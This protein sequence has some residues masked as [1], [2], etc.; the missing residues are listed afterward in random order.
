M[1]ELDS[2]S[3]AK[4]KGEEGMK[5]SRLSVKENSMYYGSQMEVDEF[6]ALQSALVKVELQKG[7]IDLGEAAY[8]L[9]L[10]PRQWE[11]MKRGK[12]II[13]AHIIYRL[14]ILLDL[15]YR[16]FFRFVPFKSRGILED[17]KTVELMKVS[18]EYSIED[19]E[20]TGVKILKKFKDEQ[21]KNWASESFESTSEE[22]EEEG[23][24]GEAERKA[25]RVEEDT[26]KTDETYE[27]REKNNA[28]DNS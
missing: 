8:L 2:I 26:E 28:E 19:W 13:P 23:E 3:E 9:G 21:D 6:Y 7:G 20:G 17:R 25:E 1:N 10:G 4:R 11:T 15:P 18:G 12:S 14:S 24:E 22:G 5:K 16:E 27:A